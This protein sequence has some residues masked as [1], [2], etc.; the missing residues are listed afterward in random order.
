MTKREQAENHISLSCRQLH[1]NSVTSKT[2]EL[3]ES[4]SL[5]ISAEDRTK[6]SIKLMKNINRIFGTPPCT[7][8]V[9][10]AVSPRQRHV[11]KIFGQYIAEYKGEDDF[12]GSMIEIWNKDRRGHRVSNKSFLSTLLHE[13]IHHYD[14]HC[15]KIKIPNHGCGF[16][17]RYRHLVELI[18]R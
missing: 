15:L 1:K 11:E 2:I 8:C 12:V 10:D 18:H 9:H 17:A 3:V 7:V 4:L 16:F 5:V 14:H 6:L 13:Y